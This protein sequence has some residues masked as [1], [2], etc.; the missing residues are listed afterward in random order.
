M[1]ESNNAQFTVYS[2]EA[3][4]PRY[5]R[6]WVWGLA[7][8]AILLCGIAAGWWFGR[9]AFPPVETGRPVPARPVDGAALLA[10]QEAANTRLRERIAVLEQAL[11][12]DAC[13]PAVLDALTQDSGRR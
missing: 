13:A 8:L 5:Q 4:I 1:I 10:R 6:A 12:G 3:L 7:A 2:A 11:A 9:T